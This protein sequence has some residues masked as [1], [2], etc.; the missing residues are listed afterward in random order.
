MSE[1]ILKGG[2]MNQ[3]VRV[4]DTVR[5][6][7]GAWTPTIHRLLAHARSRGASWAPEPF[8]IDEQGREILSFIPGEVPHAMPEWVWSE[9]VLVSVAR[10]L[11]EW[12]DATL[13]FDL[14]GA[15]WNLQSNEP[16]EVVCHN[17]FAPY[18]CVFRDALFAGA[19]D[20]DLCSPGP[21]LW[22][23]AYTAYRFVPLMPPR[24]AKVA[25][26]EQERSPFDEATLRARLGAFSQAYAGRS[27]ALCYTPAR[28]LEYTCRRLERIADWTTEHVA[29]TGRDTLANHAR[30][31]RAHARWLAQR[32]WSIVA[33]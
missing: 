33:G 25:D 12:H 4:G 5:R 19:F 8:G 18:N 21:R 6:S 3:V 16:H 27:V 24:D 29:K 14:S 32:D 31:Y 13:E 22:D 10:A 11:R 20:F 1:E 30:M 23:I 7:T 17:D 9:S 2:H 15:I 26:G 28:V